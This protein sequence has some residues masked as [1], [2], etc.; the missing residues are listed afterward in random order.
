MVSFLSK[1]FFCDVW[2]ISWLN[3]LFRSLEWRAQ[4]MSLGVTALIRADK[5]KPVYK[6]CGFL[7][8]GKHHGKMSVFWG[9]FSN[10]IRVSDLQLLFFFL[11]IRGAQR[12][13]NT[14]DMCS[15]WLICL[16]QNKSSVF[17][18]EFY[19]N[20][21]QIIATV[22]KKTKTNQYVYN[23]LLRFPLKRVFVCSCTYI[24]VRTI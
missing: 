5:L 16:F 15:N 6:W 21:S 19:I 11:R 2:G 7:Q 1:T 20:Q 4:T 24:F 10:Q 17:M 23:L 18:F 14:V 9:S 22:V 8:G 3:S 12:Q 13:N